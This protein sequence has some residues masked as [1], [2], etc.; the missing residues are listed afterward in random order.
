[1][2]HDFAGKTI[3]IVQGSLL[4]GSELE[5]AFSRAGARVYITANIISAFNLLHR[6]RFDGAVIDRGLHNAAFDLCSEL[7]DLKIPYLSCAAPHRLQGAS[8]RSRDADH[9]LGRL[10]DIISSRLDMAGGYGMAAA[11]SPKQPT[12]VTA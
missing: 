10:A 2:T 6:V 5:E 12:H 4:A 7:H 3:L 9:A 11:G 1:M 8:A